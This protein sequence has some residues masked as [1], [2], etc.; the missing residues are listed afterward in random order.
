MLDRAATLVKPGGRLVFAL[1]RF[2][3]KKARHRLRL[4]SRGI[5]TSRWRRSMPAEVA[6][7]SELLTPAGALRTLPCHSF[8]SDPMLAG[9]DGF[10][11][12]RFERRV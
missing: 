3:R 12:A 9:M 7:L 5:R 10:F 4:S 8:G 1:A 6:G 11:A 2:S